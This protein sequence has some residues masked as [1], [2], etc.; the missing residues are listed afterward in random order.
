MSE[1]NDTN[2]LQDGYVSLEG[3]VDS[4]LPSAL[5]NPNQVSW[6]V[7]TTF[8]DGWPKPRPGFRKIPL[9][10]PTE[11]V[12]SG[13]QDGYFQG[14]GT[15]ITDDRRA[16]LA[17]SVSGRIFTIEIRPSFPVAELTI[18]GDPN[19][20]TLPHAWFQ[21]A[22]RWLIVQNGMNV[23]FLYNGSGARR[24]E[25]KEV[26]VGGPMAYGKGRL[27]VAR[28]SLY[29]GGDIVWGDPDL[30]RDTV[31]RFTENDFLNEGG[32]FAAPDGPITGMTFA[33]NLDTSLG[34][35]DLLVGTPSTIYAF[36]APIDRTAWKNT[37]YP[38]QRYAV[39]EFGAISHE[40]MVLFNN[41]VIYRSSDGIRSLAY[42]RRD[43]S[44]QWGSAPISREISRALAFDTSARLSEGSGVNFDLR[45]MFTVQPQLDSA[46][47]VW[48]RGLAILDFNRVGGTG[49]NLPPIWEGVWTGL[50]FL[51]VLQVTVSG[52]PRC[53][54]FALSNAGQIQ[55][56]ELTRGAAFDFD[57]SDDV[58]IEWAVESRGMTF[59]N[60]NN[61]KRL[62]GSVQWMDKIL[63]EVQVSAKYRAD[64]S[65]CWRDWATWND[66]V[67]YRACDDAE[68][69]SEYPGTMVRPVETYR[70]QTRPFV[71]LPQP[72]DI[73]EQQTGGFTRDGYEFQ[74][75]LE[76]SGYFRLKRF[77]AI[78]HEPEQP[79]YGNLTNTTCP[80]VTVPDCP[81][82]TC[83]G[84]TCCDP[85]DYG[86]RINAEDSTLPT[87]PGDPDYPVTPGDPTYPG[88]TSPPGYPGSPG[89]PVDPG[90]VGP[91]D[92]PGYDPLYQPPTVTCESGTAVVIYSSYVWGLGFGE[93]PN[94]V[95]TQEQIDCHQ[96][97]FALE[98]AMWKQS[99]EATGH[100]VTEGTEIK[101]MYDGAS[102]VMLS[103][104]RKST[105][106]PFDGID[107]HYVSFSGSVTMA[108]ALCVV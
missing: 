43:E 104:A 20:T 106:N 66:C 49:R 39:R 45:A 70:A 11:Y 36:N 24:A 4:S 71:G 29:F 28:G 72:P 84:V 97:L 32:A 26:P 64:E 31:V 75:R 86:Y 9:T 59:G 18:S 42:T 50:R 47:G 25:D 80:D 58:P 91:S 10:F 19:M 21:Q 89:Y 15:Y 108:K 93:D 27:W 81:T 35:G 23:P 76:C 7:N 94:S 34:D 63:G 61:V 79:L 41:D 88:E 87:Y 68:E 14:A 77:V 22:E 60:P 13:M 73:P 90:A 1:V 57:G 8:R 67:K 30:G 78:A 54:A 100:T 52:I 65:E 82:G 98:V 99:Y 44:D 62:M 3:G 103:M 69:C 6:A 102:G 55:L 101:W 74:V 2:R 85:D 96:A 37:D 56:W 92:N 107:D 48:H 12:R 5:L 38:L 51:R 17:I 46:H 40:S 16:F 83:P 53:F 95:L 33:A 105:C